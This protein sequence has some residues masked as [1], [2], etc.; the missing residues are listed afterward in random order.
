MCTCSQIFFLNEYL[1]NHKLQH[2]RIEFR[3]GSFTVHFTN[4]QQTHQFAENMRLVAIILFY[5]HNFWSMPKSH[6]LSR[7]QLKCTET[8][9]KQTRIEKKGSREKSEH[10]NAHFNESNSCDFTDANN[11]SY[12]RIKPKSSSPGTF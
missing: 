6:A 10:F 11:K 8:N 3:R 2:L 7:A 5:E 4:P 12:F 1:K 9:N